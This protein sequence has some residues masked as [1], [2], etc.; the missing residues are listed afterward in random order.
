[1]KLGNGNEFVQTG[2]TGKVQVAGTGQKTSRLGKG[3]TQIRAVPT[4][5]AGCA[6]EPPP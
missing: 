5:K 1:V 6:N 2:G 4:G 3:W